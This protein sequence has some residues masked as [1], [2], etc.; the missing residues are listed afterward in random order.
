MIVPAAAAI[1]ATTG[2]PQKVRRRNKHPGES[3]VF[4]SSFAPVYRIAGG[5]V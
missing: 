2:V 1:V 5:S 4:C 3:R